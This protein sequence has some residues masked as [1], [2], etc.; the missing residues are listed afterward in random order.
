MLI[1]I[2]T[3]QYHNKEPKKKIILYS[4]RKKPKQQSITSPLGFFLVYER[5]EKDNEKSLFSSLGQLS[6]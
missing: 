5:L 2:K 6:L 3:P 1:I 4:Y